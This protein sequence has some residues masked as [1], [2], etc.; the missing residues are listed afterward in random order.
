V[1]QPGQQ[2]SVSH[3]HAHELLKPGMMLFGMSLS[4][5]RAFWILGGFLNGNLGRWGRL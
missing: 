3:G 5:T 4:T 2:P 1:K